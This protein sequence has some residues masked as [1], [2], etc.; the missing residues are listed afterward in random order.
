M[1]RNIKLPFW[2]E[3]YSQLS[4]AKLL[5][6]FHNLEKQAKNAEEMDALGLTRNTYPPIRDQ[7]IDL[8]LEMAS[9]F[10][11]EVLSRE[12]TQEDYT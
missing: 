4:D 10:E 12:L 9:R 2:S 11:A 3:E 8:L 5:E 6:A 1:S 7:L